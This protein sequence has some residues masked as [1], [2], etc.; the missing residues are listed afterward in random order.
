MATSC[1]ARSGRRACSGGRPARRA[2][3]GLP[4]IVEPEPVVCHAQLEPPGGRLGQAPRPTPPPPPPRPPRP[5]AP[6]T[7]AS[8]AELRPRRHRPLPPWTTRTPPSASAALP[9]RRRPRRRHLLPTTSPPP[10]PRRTASPSHLG[11]LLRAKQR[12]CTTGQAPASSPARAVSHRRRQPASLP[13]LPLA[14]PIRPPPY[15]PASMNRPAS[16]N[17]KEEVTPERAAG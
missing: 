16:A 15:R 2:R 6:C 4:A 5:H 14:H 12:Y 17:T 9:L 3:S 11:N 7:S 13:A 8:A 1:P 10:A